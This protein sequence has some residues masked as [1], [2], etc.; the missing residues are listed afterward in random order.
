MAE[1]IYAVAFVGT[2]ETTQANVS[3]LLADFL[4]E[5]FNYNP[6]IFP[7]GID[8]SHVGLSRAYDWIFDEF[9]PDSIDRIGLSSIVAELQT[10]RKEGAK[11]FVIYV[12]GENDAHA[13][14]VEAARLADIPVLDLTAG[15]DDYAFPEPEPV[16]DEAPKPRRTRGVPR[17][18]KL[19]EEVETKA[20]ESTEE[21]IAESMADP[22]PPWDDDAQPVVPDG[23]Q[24]TLSQA[25]VDLLL[26]TFSSLAQ[27]V[28]TALAPKPKVQTYPYWVNE[29]GIYRPRVG[30]GRPRKGETAV[31]L[32]AEDI[33][34]YGL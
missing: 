15:L 10:Q 18:P 19:D 33:E 28:A 29:D 8:A 27:D 25:T 30:R 31:D 24:V 13:D 22:N 23:V 1:E 14:V 12:P 26:A 2:G 7:E 32:T 4:S 20:T 11:P 3:A 5:D 6:P 9:G 17:T 21:D 16:E 34:K